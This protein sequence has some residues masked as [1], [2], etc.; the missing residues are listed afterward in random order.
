[1]AG[2]CESTV[3]TP[4]V[5]LK[6]RI[7][8]AQSKHLDWAKSCSPTLLR[9]LDAHADAIGAP[10]EYILFP[11]LTVTA[12]FVGVNAR[13]CINPE[14]EDPSIL[15]NIVVARKGEKKTAALK[16]LLKIVEV[17]ISIG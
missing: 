6:Q 8:D 9:T 12:S 16:R 11:L 1:M 7:I 3:F 10:K 4:A 17:H 13:M 5:E 14:W 2:H 15:W